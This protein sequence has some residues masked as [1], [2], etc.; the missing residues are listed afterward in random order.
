MHGWAGHMARKQEPHP[1]AA[2][3]S[4]KNVEWWEIMKGAGLV[5]KLGDITRKI[6]FAVSSTLFPRSLAGAG[7]LKLNKVVGKV[8]REVNLFSWAKPYGTG[9]DQN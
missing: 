9:E 2:V 4:Y 5:I 8:G 6:G 7:G 1:G 3:I